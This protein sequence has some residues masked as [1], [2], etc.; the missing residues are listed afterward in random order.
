MTVSDGALAGARRQHAELISR[1]RG[2]VADQLTARM[3]ADQ[4]AG[5]P[6]LD[7]TG[8]RVLA[9]QLIVDLLDREAKAALAAG[10]PVLTSSEEEQVTQAIQ[11]LL[12][13][14]GRLQRLLDDPEIENI[15]ANG[16]DRVWVRYA[17][18]RRVQV[19]PIADSDGELVELIRLAAARLGLGERRFDLASPLLDLRLPDGSRLFAAMAVVTRPCL[20]I[21]LHRYPTLTL[22]DLAGNG[23][24]DR[25]LQAFLAAAV[26]ARLNLIVSGGTSAGKTTLLRALAAEIPFDERLVTIEDSL[27]LGLERFPEVHADVVA[28]EARA[29]NVEGEGAISVADLVRAALR[30]SPDRVIVG[31]VRGHEVIPMLNAM[32]QGNDGSMCTIHANSSAGAF[33]RLAT[34][35]IQAPERLPL[36]ATNLLV[37]GAVDVV[38]HLSL[39]RLTGRRRVTSIREVTGADGPLVL[40]NELFRPGVDGLGVAAVPPREPTLERLVA[41]GFDPA[42]L[43][44]APVGWRS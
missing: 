8:Q 15:N 16:C 17:D 39:D 14:L 12:F 18:G 20:A 34:Y 41:A 9:G 29:P 6:T 40:S 1:L 32:T 36:E 42:W 7:P 38:V 10:R 13:G 33:G 21:R 11:D 3:Q 30:M 23:T 37:A 31:E 43:D 24:I 25:A 26:R 5:R 2:E 27:E 35:A 28:M 4:A 44:H 22:D 19:D